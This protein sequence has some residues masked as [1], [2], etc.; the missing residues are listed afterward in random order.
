MAK[1]STPKVRVNVK[2]AEQT[3]SSVPVVSPSDLP[4]AHIISNILS[5]SKA[6]EVKTMSDGNV[7]AV[8]NN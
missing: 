4:S 3:V 8:V 5:F 7:I 1:I 2:E 6:L